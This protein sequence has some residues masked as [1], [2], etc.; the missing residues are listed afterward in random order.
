[1]AYA[2]L[3]RHIGEWWEAEHTYSGDSKNLTLVAEP[4]GCMCEALP[5]DGSVQHGTVVNVVPGQLVRLS[6][7]LGPLQEMGVSG[8]LTW[9]FERAAAAET[10]VT[11]TYAVGGYAPGG[12]DKLAAVVDMV[13]TRQ[14]NRLADHAA[15]AAGR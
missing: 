7:A 5:N 8:S 11:L 9:Q 4:G 13:M 15:K 12:L 10:K 1:V 14:L 6:A 2:S 3:V